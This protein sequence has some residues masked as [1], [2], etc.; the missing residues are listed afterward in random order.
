MRY[1]QSLGFHILILF[2]IFCRESVYLK[3]SGTKLQIIG[4]QYLIDFDPYNFVFTCGIT[5]LD[6]ERKLKE[7]LFHVNK[8]LKIVCDGL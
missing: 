5:K 8:S 1:G 4:L 6:L 3:F 7:L 2:L